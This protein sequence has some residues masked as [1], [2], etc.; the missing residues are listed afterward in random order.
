MYLNMKY[1]Q[2]ALKL[3][4]SFIYLNWELVT[5]PTN[6]SKARCSVTDGKET[7]PHSIQEHCEEGTPTPLPR[8]QNEKEIC[9]IISHNN[10]VQ[11]WL[12]INKNYCNQYP[13]SIRFSRNKP[14]HLITPRSIRKTA[15]PMVERGEAAAQVRP[16]P[17]R[18]ANNPKVR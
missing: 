12:N 2:N 15:M 3:K 17:Q 13:V 1:I 10:K 18:N 9:G 16:M 11:F 7:R 4:Y 14:F 5:P 8:N 6:R